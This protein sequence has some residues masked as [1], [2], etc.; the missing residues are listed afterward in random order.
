MKKGNYKTAFDIFS[1]KSKVSNT[2]MA[3][4]TRE[5]FNQLEFSLQDNSTSSKIDNEELVSLKWESSEFTN[6]SDPQVWGSAFWFTLHNGAIHYPL[7]ASPVTKE[8]M[9]G[10]I[11][12][13]P[14]M[15]PCE[16]CKEH[17]TAHIEKNYDNLDDITSGRKNLFN[18]FV[19]FHNYVNKRYNKPIM[20]YE[21]AYKLYS[22]GARVS[23]LTYN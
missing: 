18:F 2:R 6:T 13:M 5:N 20:S 19:D 3:K 4:M 17:A 12:G 22:G 8:R 16:T 10:F 1:P 23:K 15:I 21:D 11:L 14:V 7:Q 9:K